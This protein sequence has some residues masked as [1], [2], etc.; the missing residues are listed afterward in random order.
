MSDKITDLNPGGLPRMRYCKKCVYPASSAVPLAFDERGICSGCRTAEQTVEIDW[1]RRRKIFERIIAE[2]RSAD[3]SNYD[4]II[5]VSGGKDS[6]WQIHL[7][8]SYNLNPLLVTYHGNNYTATGM[9]NLLNMREVF[10]CD[11]VFFT[12]SINVLKK[13]NRLGQVIMG[14]MNWHAHAGIFTYPIQI[15]V[16]Q[17]V[18]L[19]IWGEHGFMDLGGMHSYNDLVEFT[20]RYRH[21]HCLRGYEWTDFVSAAV[22]H[23]EQL[24]RKELLPW[25]YPDD[26]AIEKVGV[27]GLFISNYFKWDANVHG[28]LM[29]EKYGFKEAEEPFDRTY[30]RMSNLDDMHENGIHDYMKFVKFGYGRATDHVC[31]DIR[32]GKMTREAGIEIIM[33]MD[34]IKSSDLWR[35]L[36]YVGWAESQFDEI[37]DSF[38]DPRVWWIKDGEWWKDNING[39]PSSYGKVNISTVHQAKYKIIN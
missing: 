27:R 20:Y 33:K 11:H 7:I 26:K 28:P 35:W 21:E 39:A 22:Q 38:R 5:P 37:A 4:C 36:D 8:K 3:G 12:P 16:Q 13:M 2:Y 30:R 25:V 1:D 17:N 29:I 9:K 19:M 10:D 24:E 6:Y 31:K 18:P 34:P 32:A 15:A 23:S 14:D